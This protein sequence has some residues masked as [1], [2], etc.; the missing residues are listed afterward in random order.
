M[1]RLRNKFLSV[2]VDAVL[3]PASEPAQRLAKEQ[4]DKA[5]VAQAARDAAFQRQTSTSAPQTRNWREPA[6]TF[7]PS[8]NNRAAEP[9][10]GEMV[11]NSQ[12]PWTDGSNG[13]LPTK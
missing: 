9:S 8:L 3:Y 7:Q 5:R 4:K 11:N 2:P 1:E 6:S 13:P 10:S 12:V